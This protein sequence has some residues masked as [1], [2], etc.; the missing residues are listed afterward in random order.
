MGM[1]ADFRKFALK[2]NIVDL[3][4][5]VVIGAAFGKIVAAIVSDVVMPLV[6]LAM[7][8]GD[9]RNSGW[10]MRR[11]ATPKDDVILKWGDLI[12]V[13]LD[14][15]IVA[16]VLFLIVS[17]VVKRLEERLGLSEPPATKDCPYCIE[18]IPIAATRCKAC[19]SQLT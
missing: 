4:V 16:F 14:F 17:K 3:A 15:V 6:S 19:T 5:A 10:I 8:S 7:P 18:A 1:M 9:W 12:G 2:G 13:T 11:G